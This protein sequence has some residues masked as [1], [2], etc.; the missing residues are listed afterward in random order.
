MFIESFLLFYLLVASMGNW[1]FGEE[2]H[3]EAIMHARSF[4]GEK[5]LY[6]AKES[7]NFRVVS[8]WRTD[9]KSPAQ[10]ARTFILDSA[11]EGFQNEHRSLPASCAFLDSP[12]WK[13]KD[14]L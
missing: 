1:N 12:V 6:A 13:L 10:C 3:C 8:F 5:R 7:V 9:R 4:I 2:I 11:S 14:F